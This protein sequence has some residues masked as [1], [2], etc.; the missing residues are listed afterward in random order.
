[1]TT[2]HRPAT[3]P[4]TGTPGLPLLGA[5][6][7]LVP[8][9]GACLM[10]YTAVLAGEPFSDHPRC[11]HPLLATLARLV[12][13]ATTDEGR[14]ALASL[15]PDLAA[16]PRTDAAD[17]AALVLHVLLRTREATGRPRSL[18]R[19]TRRALRRLRR[20][21]DGGLTGRLSRRLEPV[22]RHGSGRRRLVAA[23]GTTARLPGAERDRTLR[24]LLV[25]ALDRHRDL[26]AVA[27]PTHEADEPRIRSLV[28]PVQVDELTPTS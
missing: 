14:P 5:G 4:G 1:M 10:E 21:V 28:A 13:D 9:D 22:H 15:A 3:A 16:A 2:A 24:G 6:A 18:E 20:V 11:T 25:A 7:H 17:A 19:H 27:A 23:V 26:A 12:N 8:E